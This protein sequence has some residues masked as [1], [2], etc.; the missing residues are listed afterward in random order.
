MAWN[1]V[2]CRSN[3]QLRLDLTEPNANGVIIAID[4]F[5]LEE[6]RKHTL[7]S[8]RN[9]GTLARGFTMEIFDDSYVRLWRNTGNAGSWDNP[10]TSA[11]PLNLSKSNP[12]FL[13]SLTFTIK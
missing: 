5:L 10:V 12:F 3:T 6:N 4:I 1:I 8:F 9:K 2:Q 13:C 7:F 11:I